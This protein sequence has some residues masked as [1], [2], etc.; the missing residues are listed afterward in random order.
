MPMNSTPAERNTAAFGHLVS[1]PFPI[2]GPVIFYFLHRKSSRFV[3]L[4]AADILIGGI[5]QSILLASAMIISALVSLGQF[6]Q[7]PQFTWDLLWGIVIKAAVVWILLGIIYVIGVI[8][9]VVSAIRAHRGEWQP[10]GI[11]GRLAERL[12]VRLDGPALP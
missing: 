10:K 1:I 4:N 3:S 9:S 8:G 12:V 6:L 2:W 5:I 11:S 7:N